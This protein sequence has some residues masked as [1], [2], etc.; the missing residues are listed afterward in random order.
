MRKKVVIMKPVIGILAHPPYTHVENKF[1]QISC[2]YTNSVY[3]AGGLPFIIPQ[4]DDPALIHE[5]AEQIDG[6]LIPGGIDVNPLMYHE[7]PLPKLGKV[8]KTYDEWQ[9]HFLE[10]FVETRKP[11][12]GICRGVQIMNVFFGGT[13]W[14]DLSNRENTF[15]H[16]QTEARDEVSHRVTIEKNSKLYALFG[17]ELY[18]N[19]FHHQ[20]LKEVAKNLKV[21]AHADDGVVEAVEDPAYPYLV[22]VQWHPEGFVY[23]DHSM[24]CLFKDFLSACQKD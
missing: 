24:S 9:L 19:S 14:Q 13:L 7:N 6:L 1:N 22:G 17:K 10:A 12:L 3:D 23:T 16:S 2:N 18:V 15:L 8:D 20:A 21:T 5:Y 11:V 4:I